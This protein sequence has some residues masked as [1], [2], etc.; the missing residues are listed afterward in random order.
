MKRKTSF[1]GEL[2]SRTESFI[3]KD[4]DHNMESIEIYRTNVGCG[5]RNVQE[6][7]SSL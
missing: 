2:T 1:C 7:L 6:Y 4:F 5:E 3:I